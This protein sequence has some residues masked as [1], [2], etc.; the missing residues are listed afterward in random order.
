M[1]NGSFSR[2]TAIT[3][4]ITL[5]VLA[6]AVVYGILQAQLERAQSLPGSLDRAVMRAITLLPEGRPASPHDL[7]LEL[8]GQ[9]VK[10]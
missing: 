9:G 3:S 5:L 4:A 7:A 1:M 8:G 6:L 10:P 2:S